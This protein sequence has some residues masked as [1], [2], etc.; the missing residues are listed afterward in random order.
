MLTLFT[1]HWQK[2]SRYIRIGICVLFA[3]LISHFLVTEIFISY[4]PQVRPDIGRYAVLRIG[5]AVEGTRL[6]LFGREAAG[7]PSITGLRSRLRQIA[8]GVRASNLQNI[9]YTQVD[10]DTIEWKQVTYTFS[11]GERTTITI[12]KNEP[13]PSVDVV[14]ESYRKMKN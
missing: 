8:P 11:D 13:A 9:T 6:A 2:Y 1:R 12:P 4:T 3:Y 5:D 10:L 14:E 7:K